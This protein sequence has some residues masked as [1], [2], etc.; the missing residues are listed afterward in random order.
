MTEFPDLVVNTDIA[1]IS[2]AAILGG[3]GFKIVERFLNSKE[4]VSEHTSLRSELRA[5]LTVVREEVASLR[6]EVDTWRDRYY[7]QVEVNTTLQIELAQLR[8]ELEEYK[9]RITFE[10]I[11][12]TVSGSSDHIS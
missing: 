4:F 2:V 5:E 10:Y 12:P 6:R 11:I 1:K 9:E 8:L 7:D 3:I